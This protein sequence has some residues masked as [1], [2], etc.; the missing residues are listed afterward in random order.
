MPNNLNER[1]RSFCFTLNNYTVD[2]T[3]TL[4]GTG[5]RYL[6]F[7]REVGDQGTAHLQGYVYFANARTLRAVIGKLPGAHVEVARGSCKA[8]YEYCTKSGDFSEFGESPGDAEERGR[9][10]KARWARTLSLAKEGKIDEIEPDLLIR[11]YGS[12]KRIRNDFRPKP[13]CLEAPCGVWIYGASGSGK[14]HAVQARYPDHYKKGHNKWWDGY[15]GEPVAYLDD[16]GQGDKWLGEFYLKHWSD[17]YPFA[18]ES[19]GFCG[20]LRPEKLIVTS[21]YSIEEIW[22]DD[23]TRD[24]LNRRFIVIKKVRE[25][26]ILI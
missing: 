23:E 20:Q 22:Q 19:K 2:N 3:P 26:G 10:E 12:L 14:S 17:R 8:N 24:A 21:Q 1:S 16:I 6:L 9:E 25:Q 4:E 18:A 11:Y 7:G 15:E 13:L 5:A